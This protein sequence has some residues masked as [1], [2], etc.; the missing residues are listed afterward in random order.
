[1]PTLGCKKNRDKVFLSELVCFFFE[2]FWLDTELKRGSFIT[3]LW[4][5]ATKETSEGSFFD[6]VVFPYL[7]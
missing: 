7:P 4:S 1:M 5:V 2:I 6:S 3:A